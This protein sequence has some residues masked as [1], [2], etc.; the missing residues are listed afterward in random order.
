[1]GPF[2]MWSALFTTSLWFT[3]R[4]SFQLFKIAP[5]DFSPDLGLL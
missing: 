5:S 1:M 3:L 4:A 2:A